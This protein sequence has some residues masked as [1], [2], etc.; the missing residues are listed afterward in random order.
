MLRQLQGGA[1]QPLLLIHVSCF[2]VL[3]VEALQSVDLSLL[4]PH[5]PFNSSSLSQISVAMWLLWTPN[6]LAALPQNSLHYFAQ[7]TNTLQ[8]SS[9][10][11]NTCDTQ[12]FRWKARAARK[13]CWGLKLRAVPTIEMWASL[14][15]GEQFPAWGTRAHPLK[16]GKIGPPC[17]F[18]L[19]IFFAATLF[20]WLVTASEGVALW[21]PRQWC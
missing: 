14:V 13:L 7:S 18:I 6:T 17:F 4:S 21:W 8:Y 12:Y 15:L 1:R 2:I 11:G 16:L 10:H 19:F 5:V 9:L 3:L 20:M